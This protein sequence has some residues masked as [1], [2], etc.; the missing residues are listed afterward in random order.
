MRLSLAQT[1]TAV[2]RQ[3]L[4]GNAVVEALSVLR[5]KRLATLF[6][7]FFLIR[8]LSI[9]GFSCQSEGSKSGGIGTNGKLFSLVLSHTQRRIPRAFLLRGHCRLLPLAFFLSHYVRL[10][11]HQCG[12]FGCYC[13]PSLRAR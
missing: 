12:Y 5:G 3:W 2:Q 8:V 1:V 7:R 9:L 4:S 6:R 10:R 11:M 13:P